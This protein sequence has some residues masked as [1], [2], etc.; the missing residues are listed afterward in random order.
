MSESAVGTRINNLNF[1]VAIY[2]AIYS[3]MKLSVFPE[4]GASVLNV[5]SLVYDV[6]GGYCP[7]Y[8]NYIHDAV[9]SETF[10]D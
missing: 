9:S 10:R 1:L 8:K 7:R 5:A 4:N 3:L 2:L 6:G